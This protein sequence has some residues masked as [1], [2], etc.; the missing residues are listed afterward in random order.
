[1][2]LRADINR[3]CATISQYD[4]INVTLRLS[5]EPSTHHAVELDFAPLHGLHFVLSE[6]GFPHPRIVL[7]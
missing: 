3:S 7:D 1:M 6:I 4:L 2:Y 5:L